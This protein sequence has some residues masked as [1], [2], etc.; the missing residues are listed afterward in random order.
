MVIGGAQLIDVI[1]STYANNSRAIY[2][3]DNVV[4]TDQFDQGK[5]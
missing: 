4:A 5:L 3:D 1:V 2:Y